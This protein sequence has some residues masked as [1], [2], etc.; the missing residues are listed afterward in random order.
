MQCRTK[1][2]DT[3][4]VENSLCSFFFWEGIW[5]TREPLSF[6]KVKSVQDDEHIHG[7]V[8]L[9]RSCMR[10]FAIYDIYIYMIYDI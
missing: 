9:E 1:H 6:S 5:G 7:D 4:V 2:L 8:H 3:F 10:V